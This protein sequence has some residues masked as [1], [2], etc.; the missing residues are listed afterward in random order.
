MARISLIM[1]ESDILGVIT[2]GNRGQG[3]LNPRIFQ[4]MLTGAK[5]LEFYTDAGNRL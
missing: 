4:S 3:R 1:K 5:Q 2:T